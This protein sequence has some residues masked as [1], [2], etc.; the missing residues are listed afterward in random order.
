MMDSIAGG[1]S[2]FPH[3]R[4][5]LPSG[6]A[7]SAVADT[8]AASSSGPVLKQPVPQAM[9]SAEI[10]GIARD[11]AA[12]PPVDRD[13]VEA[14]RARL[15]SGNFIPDPASIADAMLKHEG[16]VREA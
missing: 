7:T 6:T 13:R 4:L 11:L 14:L 5:D 15:A 3:R 2:A 16:H 12:S 10:S 9:L 1:P 8:A